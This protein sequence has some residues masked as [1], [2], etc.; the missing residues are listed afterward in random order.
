M[1]NE[2]GKW[3]TAANVFQNMPWQVYYQAVNLSKNKAKVVDPNTQK[4]V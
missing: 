4:H 3:K 2:G 1:V